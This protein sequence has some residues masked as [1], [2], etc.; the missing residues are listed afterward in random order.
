MTL[1]LWKDGGVMDLFVGVLLVLR[2]Q[3]VI[4]VFA[5]VSFVFLE[6]EGK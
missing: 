5:A 2:A 1:F 6:D 3:G 4:N